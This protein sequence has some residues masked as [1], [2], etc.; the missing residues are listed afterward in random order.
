MWF[1]TI[2]E[3]KHRNK[4]RASN[5]EEKASSIF[6]NCL[7]SFSKYY[8]DVRRWE[9]GDRVE[10][11]YNFWHL[12]NTADMLVNIFEVL[13]PIMDEDKIYKIMNYK[14]FGWNCM[15]DKEIKKFNEEVCILLYR[16]VV[17][18]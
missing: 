14:L 13:E 5:M 15:T 1:K 10:L 4:L 17:M 7:I 8:T 3:K 9:N 11:E 12:L 6:K 2:E 18:E 16:T